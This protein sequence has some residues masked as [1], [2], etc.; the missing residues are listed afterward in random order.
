MASQKSRFCPTCGGLY[1]SQVEVCPDDGSQTYLVADD[2]NLVGK[3]IDGRF[4]ITEIL[5]SGGMGEVYRARQHSMDRDVAVKVLRRNLITDKMAIQRFHREAKAASLLRDPHSITVFDFG[6]TPDGLLYIVMEMLHGMPLSKII[7]RKSGPMAVERAVGLVIQILEALFEAHSHSVLHRDLK[8]DNV[9]LLEREDQG[10]FVKVLDFGIAKVLDD[11]STGLTSTGMVFGTPTYMSPEQA[12]GLEMDVRGD[13]YSVGV[14]LFELLA[15][16]PPFT[17]KTPLALMYQKINDAVPT[18]YHVNPEV[19]IPEQLNLVINRL[20]AIKP[21][22]RPANAGETK[23]LLLD[24]VNGVT[25]SQVPLPDVILKGST[26]KIAVMPD[27]GAELPPVPTVPRLEISQETIA[28]GKRPIPWVWIFLMSITLVL[29]G[30]VGIAWLITGDE[31]EAVPDSPA[32]VVVPDPKPA[33][34]GPVV[35]TRKDL[36][37]SSAVDVAK[38]KETA[39]VPAS[40]VATRTVEEPDRLDLPAKEKIT[41]PKAVD[42]RTRKKPRKKGVTTARKKPRKAAELQPE[43]LVVPSD[44]EALE[45]MEE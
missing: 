19:Q 6:Q 43:K 2:E 25:G 29:G 35:V 15:G 16:K 4:T 30:L 21:E 23:K 39:D 8:P 37:P 12:Q 20:L 18:I 40:D 11:K 5:G 14:M 13:L 33:D 9:F 24:A 28:P 42:K 17:A 34:E 3:I 1:D 45:L 22:E 32:P 38:E 10:D 31:T 26:T 36:F 44:H 41:K 7:N 27:P